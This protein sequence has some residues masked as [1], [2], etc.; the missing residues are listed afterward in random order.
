MS[1]HRVTVFSLLPNVISIPQFWSF[2]IIFF[3]PVGLGV[4]FG[5]AHARLLKLGRDS[6]DASM[7]DL[8]ERRPVNTDYA[9]SVLEQLKFF[10][11]HKLLTDITLLVE[12][13]EFPCHKMVLAT[14][15]SYF[16]WVWRGIGDGC[17]GCFGLLGLF[18]IMAKKWLKMAKKHFV[19]LSGDGAV[20]LT[21]NTSFV[22]LSFCNYDWLPFFLLQRNSTCW[23]Y[24]L[25]LAFC[26]GNT[27]SFPLLQTRDRKTLNWAQA[28]K[29]GVGLTCS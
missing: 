17:F 11:E 12:D 27:L 1:P 23:F 19:K 14:C 9:V 26:W 22:S 25:V 13:N 24:L 10:Y 28:L 3:F 21:S 7:S 16:R 18:R 29:A 4:R 20:H 15:S 6:W 2:I 5:P 8:G